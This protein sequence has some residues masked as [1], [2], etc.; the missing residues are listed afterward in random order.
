MYTVKLPNF[1]GPL[2]LLLFFIK[3]DELDI[4]DIPIARITKEFL[5]YVRLMQL[6]DLEL[7]GE[8]LVMAS[9][10]MQIKAKMLLPKEINEQGE[11]ILTND[12]RAELVHQLLQYSQYKEASKDLLDRTEAQKYVYYRQLFNADETSNETEPYKNA[13]LFDLL[14][15]F[16]VA[17]SRT[18]EKITT[19]VI[20]LYSI[21]I[22]EQMENLRGWIMS[23]P[24]LS[25][26]ELCSGK[27][28]IYIVVTF[29]AMLEM[30]K[31][32]VLTI[33]QSENF[34]DIEILPYEQELETVSYDEMM[35]KE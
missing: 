21:T 9:M 18:P 14:R 7:A 4:N 3:R 34:D 10:L 15:A 17:L 23:T 19:H 25:F 35:S 24:K 12:P 32:Q 11:E 29:L 22:E 20:Q 16:K 30:A 33:K 31:N 6:F 27:P 13:T 1:E 8:F 26:I 5:D 2:D 28:R